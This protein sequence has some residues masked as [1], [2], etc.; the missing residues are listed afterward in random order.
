MWLNNEVF[1]AEFGYLAP[2]RDVHVFDAWDSGYFVSN[3]KQMLEIL[4]YADS[5]Q[6]VV[7]DGFGGYNYVSHF[8][9]RLQ[10]GGRFKAVFVIF[11]RRDVDRKNCHCVVAY[12]FWVKDDG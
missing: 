11:C 8:Y 7:S 3:G 2:E 5:H 1:G 6:I 12:F 4:H 10:Y 9:K